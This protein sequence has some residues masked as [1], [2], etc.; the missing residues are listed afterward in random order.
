MKWNV[1]CIIKFL[2]IYEHYPLLWNVKDENYY[3]T[4]LKDEVFQR[5]SKELD[6]NELLGGMDMKQL[7]TNIISI[8]DVYRQ[9][10]HKI[11]KSKKSGCGAEEVYS[12]KLLWFHNASFLAEVIGTRQS[13]SNLVSKNRHTI[14]V[15]LKEMLSCTKFILFIF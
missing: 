10:L 14:N 11:E 9:E 5:L 3:N 8:K 4:K 2:S 7:D 12:P 6:E 13:T 1:D 15:Y